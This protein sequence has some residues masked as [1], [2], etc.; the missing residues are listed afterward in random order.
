MDAFLPGLQLFTRL[1]ALLV[2]DKTYRI[3]AVIEVARRTFYC[4]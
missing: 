1:L 2:D 3:G 4:S